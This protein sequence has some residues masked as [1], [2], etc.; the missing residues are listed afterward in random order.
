MIIHNIFNNRELVFIFYIFIIGLI[1]II[2]DNEVIKSIKTLIGAALQKE[3]I[4]Y[5]FILIPYAVFYIFLLLKTPYWI[6]EYFKDFF[7]WFFITAVPLA[8][9]AI[10]AKDHPNYF[11]KNIIANFKY[12]SLVV[13]ILSN[14]TYSFIVELLW[15]PI[16]FY[17]IL[18]N[19]I[20][21]KGGYTLQV[22][23]LTCFI[24]FSWYS[25]F[26]LSALYN[27]AVQ[28]NTAVIQDLIIKF[29]LPIILSMVL[30][31]YIYIVILII[32]YR[33]LFQVLKSRE[34]CSI[35]S[36]IYHRAKLLKLCGLSTTRQNKFDKL[37]IN[38]MNKSMKDDDFHRFID[39][40]KNS[41]S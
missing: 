19:N 21:F 16:S 35:K 1:V 18:I 27:I 33:D 22:K 41:I 24:K 39:T 13:F 6:N 9:N 32:K 23:I 25:F 5:F 3:L 29:C 7:V 10:C 30:T 40:F 37:V 34:T 12:T 36:K 38:N 15:V 17:V 26:V 2:Q 11:R 4:L 31:P 20:S 8:F 28:N 14:S